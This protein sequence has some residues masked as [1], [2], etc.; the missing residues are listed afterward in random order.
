MATAGSGKV[1]TAGSGKETTAGLEKAVT[2]GSGKAV[3]IREVTAAA[4][5]SIGAASEALNDRDRRLGA[6]R[7]RGTAAAEPFDFRPTPLAQRPPPSL[8]RS[9][10]FRPR[11]SLS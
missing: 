5:T 9:A 10:R 6:T 11:S 2:A 8:S 3:A 1:A 4:G 7:V